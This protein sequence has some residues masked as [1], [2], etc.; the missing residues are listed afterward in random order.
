MHSVLRNEAL[1]PCACAH[2]TCRTRP[3]FRKLYFCCLGKH[4]QTETGFKT[5]SLLM[6]GENSITS[7]CFALT[8]K[9][10][11]VWRQVKEMLV[12]FSSKHRQARDTFCTTEQGPHSANST[13]LVLDNMAK[14]KQVSKRTSFR[15]RER[16]L[17]LPIALIWHSNW[18][19]YDG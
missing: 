12:L 18:W 10:A 11:K 14:L 2:A 1:V 4:S 6:K 15:W 5:N 7:Y 3:S 13:F 9:L 16:T 17:S 19:K 8:F